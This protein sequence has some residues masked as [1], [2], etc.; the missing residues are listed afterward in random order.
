MT[1]IEKTRSLVYALGYE[2]A[3]DDGLKFSKSLCDSLGIEAEIKE[4]L[5]ELILRGYFKA[6]GNHTISSAKIILLEAWESDTVRTKVFGTDF[7]FLF[8]LYVETIF[9]EI[10]NFYAEQYGKPW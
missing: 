10:F 3:D 8:N 7:E 5:G 1:Q 2:S 4:D 9:R 6:Y